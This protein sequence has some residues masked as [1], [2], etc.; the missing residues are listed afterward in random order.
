MDLLRSEVCRRVSPRQVSVV[1]GALRH[2]PDTYFVKRRRQ[3]FLDEIFFQLLKRRQHAGCNRFL[4]TFAQSIA[5]R[6][7]DRV[8]KL[9]E[10]LEERA[11]VRLRHQLLVDLRR[12]AIQN[13]LR[14][15]DVGARAFLHE[16]HG[17]VH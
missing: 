13:N 4:G 14:P 17:L 5:V 11:V 10:R 16:R 15:H 6:C 2:F 3:I 8:W 12:D 9:L 7:A 1:I